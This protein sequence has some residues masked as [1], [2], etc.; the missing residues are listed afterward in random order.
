MMV[1]V[2]LTMRS[3]CSCCYWCWCALHIHFLYFFFLFYWYCSWSCWYIHIKYGNEAKQHIVT[4]RSTLVFQAQTVHD[5][6]SNVIV[7][8]NYKPN[9][10]QKCFLMRLILTRKWLN[11]YIELTFRCG[12]LF[13]LFHMY[14]CQYDLKFVPFEFDL[15]ANQNSTSFYSHYVI[16]LPVKN[17]HG[18]TLSETPNIHVQFF[19]SKRMVI[20]S[21]I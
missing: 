15:L 14:L 16:T 21:I 17:S 13:F 8:V 20:E 4:N 5:G 11:V 7:C 19:S 2:I 3:I 12:S 9:Y 6:F 1:L 10:K 18:C